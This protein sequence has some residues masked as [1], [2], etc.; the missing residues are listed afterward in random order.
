MSLD[1]LARRA[2]IAATGLYAVLAVSCSSGGGGGTAA[3]GIDLPAEVSAVAAREDVGASVRVGR[4]K[5]PGV[6]AALLDY[7]QRVRGAVEDLPEGSDYETA[8]VRKFVEIEALD[9]FEIIDTI[10]DAVR[11]THYQD[12]VGDGWYKT[13]VAFKDEGEGGVQQTN[14][15]EWYVR[16]LI[17]SGGV[18]RVQFKIKEIDDRGI[19]IIRVQADVEEAPTE[20]EDGTLADLGVWQIRAIFGAEGEPDTDDF[21]HATADVTVDGLSQVTI[22]ESFTEDMGGGE[23]VSFSTRAVVFRSASEGYGSA[24]FPDWDACFGPGGFDDVLCADGPPAQSIEFAYNDSYLSIQVEGEDALSFDREDEH[25]IVH[26]YALF[27]GDTGS[28]VEN[29]LSFGFPVTVADAESELFGWYGAWQDRHQ[30]WLPT[31]EPLDDGSTV[32]RNDTR[33]G[34]NGASYT[35][36]SFAGALTRIELVEGSLAQLEGIAA[37]IWLF[38][39]FRLR[40]NDTEGRW[41]ACFG[42]DGFGECETSEDFTS[43]LP[44]L[45]RSGDGDQ[46]DIYVDHCDEFGCR[47]YVYVTT[48]G[49]GFFESMFNE[50]TGQ[51]EVGDQLD[52]EALDDGFDLWASVGGRSYIEYVGDFD[53]DPTS[54][55]WV[56]KT[57]T[58]FDESTWTPSF[59]PEGDREFRFELGRQYF[60]NNRGANLR[61]SKAAENGNSDDYDVFMEGQSVAKPTADLATIYPSNTVL[62]NS[63]DPD[64]NSTYSLNV[65][66][67][68]GDYLL[69]VYETVSQNDQDNGVSVGDVVTTDIWGLRIQDDE[70]EL[71]DATL[72]N[73]EYQEEGEFHGGVTYLID[74]SDAFV[75]LSDPIRFEPIALPQT[76]DIV[77][78]NA[79]ENWLQYSLMYDGWLHGLPDAWFELEKVGFEGDQI[80]EILSKN[81]RIPDGTELTSEADQS[82]YLVKGVDVGI[83]LGLVSSFPLGEE[84]DITPATAIDLDA[85]IPAF[86]S[87]ALNATLPTGA[88]LLYVEGIAAD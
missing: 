9:I 27:D 42:D 32:T 43:S 49:G 10:F 21:F 28:S 31:D 73:W 14:L 75:L 77:N 54:T 22:Q 34:E 60:V 64:G 51:P 63:W 1:V 19:Q 59:D 48:G 2:G 37:E 85:T 11:Q 41:D 46:R 68:D 47:Q 67:E 62:E 83:F 80:P 87:P 20:N 74:S 79:E 65:D 8:Q 56:E 4:V 58:D 38:D 36:R 84:P 5:G 50:E 66:A 29:T 6:A 45:E 18:N 81:V 26:R 88:E 82:T 69:L 76:N 35:T 53:G 44:S 61:V 70:S 72:Y 15:E 23:E 86:V 33:P 13:L 30:L 78:E 7:R 12:H 52:T 17:V 57:L 24:E 3:A 40:W 71:A 55:G 16:S 25:E 39:T